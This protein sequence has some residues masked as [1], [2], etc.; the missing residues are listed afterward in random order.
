MQRE[1]ISAACS[2]SRPVL[3]SDTCFDT[4]HREQ[5]FFYEV[6]ENLHRVSHLTT[7]KLLRIWRHVL[8]RY[9][10]GN[11][12]LPDPLSSLCEPPFVESLME[13]EIFWGIA[14]RTMGRSAYSNA[15]EHVPAVYA[16]AA[17]V[18]LRRDSMAPGPGIDS[19]LT[20]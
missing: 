15:A 11:L 9:A 14:S 18:A 5:P 1:D 6:A 2:L 20:P 13:D 16:S 12:P 7:E 3:G 8:D 4:H 10:E 19:I 17:L